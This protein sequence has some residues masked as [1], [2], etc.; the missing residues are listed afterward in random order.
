MQMAYCPKCSQE[1]GFQRKLGFGTLFAVIITCGFWLLALPFYP[2]RCNICGGDANLASPPSPPPL[3]SPSHRFDSEK[4]CPSCAEI[5]N[6]EAIK[7]RFC[8]ETFDPE[9]VARQVAAIR[10]EIASMQAAGRRRCPFCGVWDVVTA[11]RTDGGVGPWCP[12]CQK[13][14]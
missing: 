3:A 2:K 10:D 8:G 7:C 6:L 13:D 1:T 12:N 5:I 11:M 14:A 4:K 9:Q